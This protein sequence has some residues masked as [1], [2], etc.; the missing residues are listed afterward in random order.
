ME[1]IEQALNI[2][3]IM[4]LLSC[5]RV[6]FLDSYRPPSLPPLPNIPHMR[7]SNKLPNQQQ[8]LNVSSQRLSVGEVVY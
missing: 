8:Q 7:R 4:F 3:K 5:L 1:V 2:K 6:T